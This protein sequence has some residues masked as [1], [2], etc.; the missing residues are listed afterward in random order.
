M[1]RMTI[2]ELFVSRI[3]AIY[4]QQ[5][6][7]DDVQKENEKLNQIISDVINGK[8]GYYKRLVHYNMVK[9]GIPLPEKLKK[10]KSIQQI[11]VK[12]KVEQI[13]VKRPGKTKVV[14]IDHQKNQNNANKIKELMRKNKCIDIFRDSFIKHPNEVHDME[15]IQRLT[16]YKFNLQTR[17]RIIKKI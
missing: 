16:R 15:R 12:P 7:P 9:Y 8:P 11:E 3:K 4:D 6:K 2:V 1:E 13:E 14:V 10:D 17:Q 5:E